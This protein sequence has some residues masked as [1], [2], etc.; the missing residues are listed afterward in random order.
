MDNEPRIEHKNE[1]V[2]YHK[3]AKKSFVFGV[4][5]PLC[6]LCSL[7]MLNFSL[8]KGLSYIFSVYH[9]LYGVSLCLMLCLFIMV[10]YGFFWGLIAWRGLTASDDYK[11][12]WR[13]ITGTII[14]AL[15]IILCVSSFIIGFFGDH[16]TSVENILMTSV[17]ILEVYSI[18]WMGFDS[19]N[20]MRGLTKYELKEAGR[21][22]FKSASGWVG[23]GIALWFIV[24]PWYLIKRVDF[25]NYKIDKIENSNQT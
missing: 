15:F 6:M 17:I 24:F 8:P 20:I 12:S 13:G 4:V 2:Y 3:L 1:D 19:K 18:I 14:C 23:A 5:F 21:F 10:H 25:I 9:V 11:C 22:G 16:A 7:L